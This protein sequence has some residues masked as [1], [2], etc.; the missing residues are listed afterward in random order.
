[1]A[2]F[3]QWNRTR[4]LRRVTWVCGP[5]PVLAA[6]VVR[7]YR[8]RLSSVPYRALYAD[9]SENSERTLWDELLSFPPGGRLAVVYGAEKLA[10]VHM[11][12]LTEA[13]PEFYTTVFVSAEHDFARSDG[14]LA[15]HLA[16]I[17]ASRGGQ[18]VRCNVPSKAEDR[19]KLAASWWPGAT[20]AFAADLLARCGTLAAVRQACDKGTLAGLSPEPASFEYVVNREAVEVYADTIVAGNNR[21]AVIAAR[22]LTSGEVGQA[23]SQLA[24]RLDVLG[25][26]RTAQDRG[27][28]PYEVERRFH[29]DLFIQKRYGPYASSY[30]HRR[31]DRCRELLAMA[32]SA[33]HCGT[34]DGVAEAVAALW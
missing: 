34:V 9:R 7:S 4:P 19:V 15:P 27:L 32:D 11:D 18:L 5:E 20:R 3:L 16:V 22:Q 26:L 25:V 12:A 1:M 29:L 23:L 28:E 14:Q 33:W 24:W 2:T 30:G 21:E 31:R 10:G 8:D 13:A 17:Q 6:E